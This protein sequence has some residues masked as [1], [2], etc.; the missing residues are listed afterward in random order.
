M[1]KRRA[2]GEGSIRERPDG[3]WEDLDLEQGTIRVQRQVFRLNGEVVETPLKM[4][5]KKQSSDF[6]RNQRISGCRDRT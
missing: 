4:K 2:N 1:A 3:R 5:N 6:S